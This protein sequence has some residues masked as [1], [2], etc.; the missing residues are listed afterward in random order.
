MIEDNFKSQ[1]KSLPIAVSYDTG[2]YTNAHN[3]REFE[4]LY[5]QKGSA[6][7]TVNN[8]V[9][10]VSEGDMFFV[11]PYEVHA[12]RF[13]P[14]NG[15]FARICICFDC[16]IITNETIS[17]SLNNEDYKI[18]HHIKK[19]D[20]INKYLSRNFLELINAY[21]DG[22][23][24]SDSEITSYI[25]LLFI[26]LIKSDKLYNHERGKSNE[27]FCKAVIEY[28][29]AN[30]KSDITS[31]DVADALSYDKS[32]FCRAFKKNFSRTFS[33]YL[34]IYRVTNARILLEDNSISISDIA[35][36]CGFNSYSYFA[37]CFK[38][39]QGIKPS[40]YQKKNYSKASD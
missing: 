26:K 10:L 18:M 32:Y 22:S 40:E 1:Y 31:K 13:I 16:N 39:Y 19:K 12:I 9:Y 33:E 3:H 5:F 30:Y 23:E 11:N 25:T 2:V 15:L 8:K 35:T 36:Q 4:I 20:P 17:K 34:N 27:K 6:E 38:K 7:V 14:K 37:E 24:W 21:E 29:S 28:V